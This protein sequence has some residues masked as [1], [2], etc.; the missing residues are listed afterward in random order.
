VG[1]VDYD[2]PVVVVVA[3]LDEVPLLP[4]EPEDPPLDVVVVVVVPPLEP[5]LAAV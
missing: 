1:K 5:L 3:P 2:P 4:D